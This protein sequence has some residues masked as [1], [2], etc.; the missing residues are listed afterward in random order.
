[1]SSAPDTSSTPQKQ[2]LLSKL[3]AQPQVFGRAFLV[4][5]VVFAGLTIGAA[6]WWLRDY[7]VPVVVAGTILSAT[8]L[9]AGLFRL[10]YQTRPGTEADIARLLL[11][12]IGGLSGLALTLSALVLGYEWWNDI[13]NWLNAEGPG[14]ERWRALVVVL[15]MVVGLGIMFVS[16]QLGRT[17]ERSNAVVRRLLYGYNTVLAGL[18]LVAILLVLNVILA[19]RGKIPIDFTKAGRFTLS[20][21][22]QNVLKG[23]NKPVEIINVVGDRD[24]LA[25]QDVRDMLAM[26]R[27]YSDRIQIGEL[28]IHLDPTRAQELARKYPSLEQGSLLVIYDKG[29]AHQ[30]IPA[31]DL[32]KPSN[33][34]GPRGGFG[35]GPTDFTGE[36]ALLST[37]ISLS[38]G[39]QKS[40]V[41]FTQDFGELELTEGGGGNPRTD[42]GCTLLKAELE[43]QNYEV[44]PLKF[45]PTDPKVPADAGV[46]VIAGPRIPIPPNILVALRA[47]MNKGGKL[48]VLLDAAPD[49]Q[50]RK[51]LTRS[52]LEPMLQEHGVQIPQERLISLP[53]NFRVEPTDVIARM[54]PRLE[55]NALVNA[56]RD[57]LFRMSNCRPVEVATQP[58]GKFNAQQ[59]MVVESFTFASADVAA[60]PGA[61]VEGLMRDQDALRNKV[62]EVRK[63]GRIPVAAVVSE[64]SAD[65]HDPHAMMRGPQPT[66][67]RM[68]VFGTS[69]IAS[70]QLFNQS[71]GM[72]AFLVSSSLDFLRQRQTGVAGIP[73]KQQD[74]Y[75][76][77]PKTS[78]QMFRMIWL[79]PVLIA[80]SILGLGTGVWIVRRR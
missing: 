39:K 12:S 22:T 18:L 50:D 26:T 27:F 43:K 67:P 60:E 9:G 21:R 79:P 63:R 76:M 35:A 72:S 42:R 66:K 11:L 80:V 5:A 1:M 30:V 70:N 78:D 6:G 55:E 31:R 36:D 29:A 10:F 73:P 64:S 51:V 48:L 61:V 71:Q 74:Y 46:V 13:L 23:L 8:F 57:A 68:I 34:P 14:K 20:E 2:D 54:N 40:I 19:V 58:M 41:Y 28:N 69:S 45:D 56:F 44:R 59:L 16:L 3:A 65:P 38:E 62:Q 7:W 32:S 25:E 33:R 17:D 24:E 47:Y 52:G 77:P 75:D 37:L 4:A 15:V 49:S 53:I